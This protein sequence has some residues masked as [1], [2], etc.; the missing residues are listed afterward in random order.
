MKFVVGTGEEKENTFT[1]HREVACRVPIF[2][3][4]LEQDFTKGQT[5]DYHLGD[6]SAKLFNLLMQ[7]MYSGSCQICQLHPYWEAWSEDNKLAVTIVNEEDLSLVELWLLGD[8]LCYMTLQQWVLATLHSLFER[9]GEFSFALLFQVYDM[10]SE[11]SPLREF[12]VEQAATYMTAEKMKSERDKL[13]TDLLMDLV[14]Y[15]FQKY[16]PQEFRKVA[17]LEDEEYRDRWIGHETSNIDESN[18]NRDD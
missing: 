13:S 3:S 1:I 2:L 8:R 17:E 12:F 18:S 7:F 9:R 16:G 4:V 5:Q 15:G 14:L 11:G 6:V 10:T